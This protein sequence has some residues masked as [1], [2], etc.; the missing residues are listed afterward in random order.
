M[1]D[2]AGCDLFISD[3]LTGQFIACS[4]SAHGRLGY[5]HEELLNL[6]PEAIQADPEHDAAWLAARRRELL[7]AGGGTAT[8]RHRCRDNTVLEVRVDHS[9][10][11]LDGR[12]I[13]CSVA[14]DRTRS[15]RIER[16]LQE[17]I[18][19]LAEG[20]AISGTGTWDCRLADGRMRWSRQT[21]RLCRTD[22]SSYEPSLWGYTTL[23]HPADRPRWRREF[24]QAINRGEVLHSLHRLAFLD[25]SELLVSLRGRVWDDPEGKPLRMVGTISDCS[26]E[27]AIRQGLE[28]QRGGDALTGLP[29]KL[30][31]LEELN[32][33]LSGR[34][35]SDS[36]A[37][38]SLDVDGFQEINDSF[39]AEIGDQLLQA[40]ASR[41]RQLVGEKGWLAR[42]SSD[43]FLVL[44]EA[45]IRSLGD[46]MA[47]SRR[48]QA[49]WSQQPLL[50][51]HLQ[52][53]PTFCIGIASYPEHAQDGQGLLQCANTALMQ[54][55]RSGRS[56]VCAY[57]STLS[58]QIRERLQLDGELTRALA[59]GQLR[60]M[61]QPQIH[62]SGALA[63]GEVLLR[64]TNSRGVPVPPSQFIPLAEQ[65]GLIFPLSGWV[66]GRSLQQLG[67]WQERGLPLP[68]LALNISARQLELPSRAFIGELLDALEEH[69]LTPEQ[70]ELEITETALLQ[71]QL[72]ARDRLRQLADQGFRIAIDD[73]GT[74]Y[75]SLELLRNLPVHKLKIDRTFITS[76]TSSA[77][78]QTIVQATITLAR[79]LG[80]EC[81]AE[82][83]ETLAQR[84]MLE[85]LGCDLYQGYLYS[86]PLE[87]EGFE[88]WL[89]DRAESLD[90][91]MPPPLRTLRPSV[92]LQSSTMAQGR[93]PSAGEQ[94]EVLHTAMDISQEAYML[95]RSVSGAADGGIVDFLILDLNPA[96]CRY[97]QQER[98]AFIGQ[99]LLAIF[100]N[101][102]GSGLL[103]VWIS[104]ITTG[105]PTMLEDFVYPNHELFKDDRIYDIN[106]CPVNDFLVITW[107]DVTERSQVSRS[108]A[109]AA[110]LYR[111][112]AESIV[113]VV[114]LVDDSQ[115]IRWVSPSLQP[116]TGWTPMQWQGKPFRELFASAVGQ[117]EAVDLEVWLADYG[118]LRQGR[119]RLA[120]P[121][122]GWSWV[123]LSVRRIH[124]QALRSL[125]RE[126]MA[127]AMAAASGS[128]DPLDLESGYVIT[129]QP[130]DEQVL[131][132]QRL[133][134]LAHTDLLTGLE[135]RG[136]ILSWLEERLRDERALRAQP[137]AL[138]FCDFDNFKAINDTHGHAG[139]DAVLQAVAQRIRE[140]IRSHDHAGR[141]GGDE[142]LVLLDGIRSLDHALAVAQKL[143]RVME[144]PIPWANEAICASLSIGVALHGAGEDADLFLK[145]ADH[146]MYAAKAAGRRRVVAL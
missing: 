129:L 36:L 39:G 14:V 115:R 92:P 11:E 61:V 66:L 18:D 28:E 133:Q 42:L 50:L 27:Q 23:V 24:Q 136:A 8:T 13:I 140:V 89:R 17:S 49:L 116:M 35:Y 43:E 125:E 146:A 108:L 59:Q 7:A 144:E 1:A 123:E 2:L 83:V 119:L 4:G 34:G 106:A 88:Q 90:G 84:Q 21:H 56:Q 121:H 117:P 105:N 6:R 101:V 96:A 62:K 20:E 80:M 70:L 33:R 5:S 22:P 46:A 40:V 130:I 120:D 103:D 81:I 113:E 71:N 94:L 26:G 142:F 137:L 126:A 48:L 44:Q 124:D 9:V 55:K 64:W 104:V 110:A 63:G 65:S 58:R 72:L 91:L 74:G 86:R 138:L 38:L 30:A 10:I 69:R 109:D 47:L 111:L 53:N 15:R 73:F 132:E 77:E 25:G 12:P 100:P 99:M 41:L 122:G 112:L 31:S 57:S 52:F 85:E 76:L 75:S 87:L 107:R 143:Q 127:E 95:M 82:G 3:G 93:M 29:N 97:L 54:A 51:D 131:Q 60:L 98:D 68:T 145:R 135:S 141:M 102:Q 79:G 19:L 32:R 45:E 139:G 37:V 134:L 118:A 114:L 128:S 16:Q 67:A 78:D